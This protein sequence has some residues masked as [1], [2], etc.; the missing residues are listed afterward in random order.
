[1]LY[2]HAATKVLSEGGDLQ[3]GKLVTAAVRSTRFQGVGNTVVAL[4]SHGDGIESYHV[5]NYVV[6]A[7][8][9]SVPVGVFSSS[10]QQYT[11]YKRAVVWPGGTTDEPIDYLSGAFAVP[12][13]CFCVAFVG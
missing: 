6:D 5:M 2:A 7:R 11:A 10:T 3:N 8:T 12:L 9:R 1:M 13:R 4:D